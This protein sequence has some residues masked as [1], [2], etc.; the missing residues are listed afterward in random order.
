MW[1]AGSSGDIY[2]E[3]ARKRQRKRVP[4]IKH[5]KKQAQHGASLITTDSR[6]ESFSF[7]TFSPTGACKNLGS[8]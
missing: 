1:V 2:Q 8:L 4:A 7:L 3:S 5:H 6:G